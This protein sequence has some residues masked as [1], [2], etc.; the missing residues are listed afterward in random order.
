MSLAQ[1]VQAINNGLF[2]R[3]HPPDQMEQVLD[4]GTQRVLNWRRV[5]LGGGGLLRY[6]L[7]SVGSPVGILPKQVPRRSA[8]GSP[9]R[10]G[11]ELFRV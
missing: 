8:T 3:T 10:R 4:N 11:G 2:D 9:T 1:Q 6:A 5:R 7:V